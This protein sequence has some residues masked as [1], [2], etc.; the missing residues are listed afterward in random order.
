[1][2]THTATELSQ[3]ERTTGLTFVGYL[4]AGDVLIPILAR[5]GRSQAAIRALV[6]RLNNRVAA[7]APPEA[8][9][10]VSRVS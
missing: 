10:P 9:Q 5:P 1:M 2:Q 8:V 3:I 6:L 7:P 4:D